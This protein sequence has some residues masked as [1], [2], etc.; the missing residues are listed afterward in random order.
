M[1]KSALTNTLSID[2]IHQILHILPMYS[3]CKAFM[4]LFSPI[5]NI[6]DLLQFQIQ[7]FVCLKN[8]IH[9]NGFKCE[10]F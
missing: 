3:E 10:I 6:P 8:Q 7:N 9:F 1:L 4:I 2:S 5:K